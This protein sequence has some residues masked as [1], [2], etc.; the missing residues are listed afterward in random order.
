MQMR[1]KA[2][3]FSS[4]LDRSKISRVNLLKKYFVKRVSEMTQFWGV[5][6][7]IKHYRG[8]KSNKS[9]LLYLIK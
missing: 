3:L 4:Y 8:N 6:E 7:L 1:S 5:Y 2:L 9:S